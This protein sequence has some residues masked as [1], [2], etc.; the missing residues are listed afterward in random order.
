MFVRPAYRDKFKKLKF[1]NTVLTALALGCMW[2]QILELV[3]EDTEGNEDENHW[4]YSRK[5]IDY[6]SSICGLNQIFNPIPR[7]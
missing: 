6:Y 1:P 7:L 2:Y 4:F 3:L 5:L